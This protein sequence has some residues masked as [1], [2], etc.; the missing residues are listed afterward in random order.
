M[1]TR[2]HTWCATRFVQAGPAAMLV[3]TDSICRECPYIPGVTSVFSPWNTLG[4]SAHVVTGFILGKRLLWTFDYGSLRTPGFPC[5]SSADAMSAWYL[6]AH[7][8]LVTAGWGKPADTTPAR[9]YRTRQKSDSLAARG[10]SAIRCEVMARR[11]AKQHGRDVD[12]T[13]RYR[14]SNRERAS[15]IA[16]RYRAVQ[17]L[18]PIHRSCCR[19]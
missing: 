5:G 19:A 8:K 14:S 7:F 15:A 9:R 12:E 4:R 3:P 10:L 17:G 13:E 11:F 6:A 16:G 1:I 18:V 2:H